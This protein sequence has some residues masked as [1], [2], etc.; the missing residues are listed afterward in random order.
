MK[1]NCLDMRKKFELANWLRSNSQEYTIEEATIAAS[2]ALGFEVTENNLLGVAKVCDVTFK[3]KAHKEKFYK[4]PKRAGM[5]P[6]GTSN[7]ILAH[8][9][10]RLYDAVGMEYG[11]DLVAIL[12][13]RRIPK[14]SEV[15]K[16]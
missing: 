14:E 16:D 10:T 7:K 6:P 3:K 13:G 15:M 9:I 5:F 2:K 11:E 1:K 4:N 8:Y 12:K